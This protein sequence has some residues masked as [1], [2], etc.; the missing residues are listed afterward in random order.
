M[1]LLKDTIAAEDG[2]STTITTTVSTSMTTD[3]RVLAPGGTY[4]FF[5]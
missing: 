3:C 2:T 1:F 4:F 5:K